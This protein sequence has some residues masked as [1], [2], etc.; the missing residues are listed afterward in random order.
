[1]AKFARWLDV[2]N[3]V[4]TTN[5]RIFVTLFCMIITTVAYTF[6]FNDPSWEWLAFLATMSG[7]DAAQYTSKRMTYDPTV[8]MAKLNM[9]SNVVLPALEAE[10]MEN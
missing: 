6:G 9:S 7:I 3:N 5:V 1:M 10:Q 8:E 4:S 2:I